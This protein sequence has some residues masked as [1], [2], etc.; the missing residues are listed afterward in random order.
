MNEF[1]V[2]TVLSICV[3]LFAC[4]NWYMAEQDNEIL[5][6]ELSNINHEKAERYAH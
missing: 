6:A 4:T 3:G 1:K 2:L 5:R